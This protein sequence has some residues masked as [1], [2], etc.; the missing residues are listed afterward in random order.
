MSV[1]NRMRV[2]LPE[3]GAVEH[4]DTRNDGR[5]I[6]E[7]GEMVRHPYTDCQMVQHGAIGGSLTDMVGLG[8][9]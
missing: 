1:C 7:Q 5:E 9:T 3:N 2:A 8:D 6:Q 4:Q